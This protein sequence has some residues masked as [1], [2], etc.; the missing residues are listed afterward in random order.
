MKQMVTRV[1]DAEGERFKEL[2]ASLGT[3]TADA[4]RMFIHSFNDFGGFPYQVR[5]R[6]YEAF[7]SEEEAVDFADRMSMEAM[8]DAW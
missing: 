8:R 7:G 6:E 2:T 1:E 4:L 5:V 3:T